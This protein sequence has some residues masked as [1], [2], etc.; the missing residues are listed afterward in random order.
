V[1]GSRA[2]YIK[3]VLCVMQPTSR[4]STRGIPRGSGWSCAP[5]PRDFPWVARALMQAMISNIVAYLGD[6]AIRS[7]LTCTERSV[8]GAWT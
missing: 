1:A 2:G 3:C 6:P 7:S 8:G 4:H 5:D